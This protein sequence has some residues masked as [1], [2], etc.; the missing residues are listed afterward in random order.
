LEN[1]LTTS[2]IISKLKEGPDA[3]SF[4]Q[5]LEEVNSDTALE[6]SKNKD[7]EKASNEY[8]LL[9][10]V[11]NTAIDTVK[12]SDKLSRLKPLL[13]TFS[14]TAKYWRLQAG[15]LD[16]EFKKDNYSREAEI[17][18]KQGLLEE[19]VKTYDKALG[20]ES[21]TD[22]SYIW[23]K[24]GNV[25]FYLKKLDEAI[26]SYDKAIALN[27]R[28]AEAWYNKG[29]CLF[30]MGRYRDSIKSFDRAVFFEPNNS[31]AWLNKGLAYRYL[32]DA[33]KSLECIGKAITLNPKS[34]EAWFNKGLVLYS[35]SQYEP[36]ITCYER[37]LELDPTFYDAWFNKGLVLHNMKI[38]RYE[39]AVSCYQK[40]LAIYP[41]SYA[42]RA[43]LAEALLLSNRFEESEKTA[44]ELLQQTD[45][46]GYE[47][48][49]SLLLIC[50]YFL[51]GEKTKARTESHDLLKYYESL[52]IGYEIDWIFTG[53][54]E[55]IKI[56][57]LDQNV[58]MILQGLVDLQKVKN[59]KDKM[60]EIK[61]LNDLLVKDRL[62]TI[63]K[64]PDLLAVRSRKK[65]QIQENDIMILNTSSPSDF[66]ED[67]Y[68]WEIHLDAETSILS[69][70]V[71]VTYN[72]PTT[73][74]ET[75]PTIKDRE[76]GFRFESSAI[77]EFQVRVDIK[78]DDDT[79]ISKYHWINLSPAHSVM[80]SS[81]NILLN[82]MKENKIKE[83]NNI[84]H[85]HK[86]T[87]KGSFDLTKVELSNLNLSG[88]DLSGIDLISSKLTNT[89]LTE[90]N[91]VNVDLQ[92]ADVSYAILSHANLSTANLCEA[93]LS[94]A[95]MSHS[96][97]KDSNL[98]LANLSY[99]D[100]SYADL[101]YADLSYAD[102]SYA[103]LSYADL[104][105][106]NL[107]YS[108]LIG[109]EEYKG[110]KCE[111]ADFSKSINDKLEFINYLRDNGVSLLPDRVT[112]ENELKS[113][114]MNLGFKV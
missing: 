60:L 9:Y 3:Q 52:P 41:Q 11:Y 12:E 51:R 25:Q 38:R 57:K 14:E 20:L 97:L 82:L 46:E 76:G 74:V 43:C 95:K 62:S 32:G 50:I 10:E 34:S 48:V 37:A 8:M 86:E 33:T 47:F 105:H 68:N 75:T 110:L 102:L 39:D 7:Y 84:V 30:S 45:N 35:L 70:I 100:L 80:Y 67:V 24:K 89:N 53:L 15:K 65:K 106:S 71:S 90:S 64:I 93:N 4:I 36:A 59:D 6:Y 108:L 21:L 101:S 2:D 40:S 94:H 104:S 22:T 91:L 29:L 42:V 109:I 56:S 69:R 66:R 79:K 13:K 103:D 85:N 18:T 16:E 5:L 23:N 54:L 61:R 78:F 96:K 17:L 19:A 111:E 107:N 44:G 49:L 77:G 99:A 72:L 92:R 31:D 27:P 73:F 26:D 55:K 113:K 98:N 87:H 83:F 114:R 112:D 28:Y 1:K 63:K 81:R 58:K 88:I